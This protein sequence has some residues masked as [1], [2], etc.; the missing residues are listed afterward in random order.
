MKGYDKMKDN[1]FGK[2]LLALLLCL[3][4]LLL[5]ACNSSDTDPDEDDAKSEAVYA[6]RYRDVEIALGKDATPV[7]K[8]LGDADASQKVMSCGDAAGD[9]WQYRY[10]SIVLFTL[11]TA[12][13]EIVDAVVL[14]DDVA[15][16]AKGIS[17]GST[18]A[19]MKEAYG[20]PTVNGQKRLYTEGKYTLEFMIGEDGKIS[21]AEMRTD[22]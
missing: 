7:L 18:E 20:E 9:Q 21:A 6:V 4:M 10:A 15:A 22:S 14:R 13:S 5:V 8:A 12:D 2:I 1:R 17:I 16:T 19:E 11:K 3:S